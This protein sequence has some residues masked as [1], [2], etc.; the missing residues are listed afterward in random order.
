MTR[1]TKVPF[2]RVTAETLRRLHILCIPANSI[3]LYQYMRI[4]A[5]GT[6][7]FFETKVKTAEW[8]GKGGDSAKAKQR[9]FG[10]T[11]GPLVEGGLVTK[12]FA[13][14]CGRTSE[15][16][17]AS[18]EDWDDPRFEQPLVNYGRQWALESGLDVDPYAAELLYAAIGIP[19][20]RDRFMEDLKWL[21]GHCDQ[22]LEVMR[23]KKYWS[24]RGLPMRGL[25]REA[26]ER[27]D[28]DYYCDD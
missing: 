3:L 24:S 15:Y 7:R 27:D 13:G 2:T 12:L 1:D 21:S 4:R 19:I 16:S 23:S 11:V 9:W 25:A 6:G 22:T 18:I 17:V 8:F 10:H 28:P 14:S 5:G 26:A 20:T